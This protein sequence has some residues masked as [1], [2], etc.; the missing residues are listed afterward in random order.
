MLDKQKTVVALG[1]F[2]SVHIGHRKVIKTAKQLAD[3]YDANLVVYTFSGN[4]KSVTLNSSERV[5]Y[6]D[7]EREN[8]YKTLGVDDVV[9]LKVTPKLLSTKKLAFLNSINK[10]F[11]VT[12]YVCGEDYRFG[13]DRCGDVDYIRKFA[14]KHGQTLTV[15]QLIKDQDKKVSTSM[16]KSF[17]L[18]GDLEKANLLLGENYT[19]SGKVIKDRGVGQSIG[20]PTANLLI[21]KERVKLKS[22]VYKGE[23]STS[24]GK[25]KAIIN[26]G[27]RPTF[28]LDKVLLEA[29]L[30]DFNGDLYGQTIQ[31][32]FDKFIRNVMKF[33]SI[34][35][36]KNQLKKDL[37][38]VK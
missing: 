23:V 20:F 13:K 6:T 8:I 19:V 28:N 1:H 18:D 29:H 25:F 36:L 11:N 12:A 30:I 14:Q 7:S 27:P 17:L 33:E 16:I 38:E 37:T 34:E 24:Y 15:C 32:R 5:V 26:Y 31:V 10:K 4:L 2:D 3:F 21:D 22:G 35:Q 9:F